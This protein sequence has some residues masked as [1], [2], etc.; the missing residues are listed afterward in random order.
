MARAAVLS[1]ATSL[2]PWQPTEVPRQLP[3]HIPWPP[4][5]QLPRQSTVING[6]CHGIPRH[7]LRQSSHGKCHGNTQQ[8]PRNSTAVAKAISTDVKPQQFPRHSTAISTDVNPLQ[9]PRKTTAFR[10]KMP[11]QSSNTR[12]LPRNFTAI[13]TQIS[14][15]SNYCNFHGIPRQLHCRTPRQSA[16]IATANS[17]SIKRN[18]YRN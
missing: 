18:F 16:A 3:R 10:G 2:V 5:R 12:Q 13:A 4:P 14:W 6:E 15:T 8:L 7:L 11:R 9:F 1:V 17:T